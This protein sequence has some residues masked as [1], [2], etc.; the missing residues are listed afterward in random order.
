MSI[1]NSVAK[2]VPTV[3]YVVLLRKLWI[4]YTQV[5][6]VFFVTLAL[7]PG[8][9]LLIPAPTAIENWFGIILIAEFQLFDWIGRTAPRFIILFKRD[10]LWLLV[11][12]RI[13]FFVLFILCIKPRLLTDQ[14]WAY[15]FMFFFA[16]TNGYA[17]TLAMMYGP[18]RVEEHER[19]RAGIIMAFFLNFGIF[20]AVLFSI[21][22]LYFIE[23]KAGLPF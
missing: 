8:V 23:G 16:I 2:T 15:G 21:L 13:V 4:E 3:S 5:F 17:G 10:T 1:D 14:T 20:T 22:L 11:Y 9:T 19:E 6:A 18:T 7:F 12:G